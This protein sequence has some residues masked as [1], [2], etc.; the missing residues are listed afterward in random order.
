MSSTLATR[1]LLYLGSGGDR[2]NPAPHLFPDFDVV[3]LDADPNQHPD[4]LL[5]MR[6][7]RELPAESFDGVVAIH[8]LEHVL[9]H[10]VAEVLTGAFHVLRRGGRIYICVPNLHR[11][12]KLLAES[13]YDAVAYVSPAG[14]IRLIDIIFGFTPA[15]AAGQT[16]MS[17][18]TGFTPKLLQD[19]LEEARFI[20]VTLDTGSLTSLDLVGT[21]MKP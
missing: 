19:R 21:A 5:D 4:V 8:S 12:A 14:P 1:K 9:T 7:L 2:R 15:I 10:E 16:L 11:T 13:D 6:K 20:R 18:R 3:T 17:H